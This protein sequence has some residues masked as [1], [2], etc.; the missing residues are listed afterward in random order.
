[1]R[2][3][4]RAGLP[5]GPGEALLAAEALSVAGVADRDVVQAALR[6]T[7]VHRHEHFLLFDQPSA[8]SGATRRPG[9]MPPPW[10]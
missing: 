4:R 7:M 3:L 6:A 8:C 1:V 5:V 10:R 2:L 9:A